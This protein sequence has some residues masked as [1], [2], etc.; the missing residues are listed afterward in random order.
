MALLDGNNSLPDD[1]LNWSDEVERANEVADL[2]AE[3]C[4]IDEAKDNM[5]HDDDCSIDTVDGQKSN[6][7]NNNGQDKKYNYHHEREFDPTYQRYNRRSSYHHRS[8]YYRG[9]GYQHN[10]FRQRDC[11]E[12]DF[13]MY[14]H[15]PGDKKLH[16]PYFGLRRPYYQNEESFKSGY[17]YRTER[18]E[19]RRVIESP[20]CVSEVYSLLFIHMVWTTSSGKFMAQ[21]RSNSV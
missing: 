15:R 21:Q 17:N 16:D 6:K 8:G 5:Q 10:G 4:R 1:R 2:M 7:S 19:I 9:N 12:D 13:E 20:S 3:Q 11:F 14:H 18:A